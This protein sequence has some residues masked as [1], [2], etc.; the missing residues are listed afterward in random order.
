[1]GVL[2]P[3]HQRRS[4]RRAVTVPCQ[5][6]R[7]R[8]FKL[9]GETTMDL[10]LDGMMVHTWEPVLTGEDVL[11]SFCAPGL[12]MWFDAEAEVARVVHGRRPTDRGRALGLTFRRI[13]R[14]S[15]SYLKA[16]L[17]RLPPAPPARQP[18]INYAETVTRI[19]LGLDE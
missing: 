16:G 1:M 15:Q 10:S 9:L 18:R 4:L 5:V 19:F 8:D 7:E 6:V 14:L 17:E 3:L 2:V 11:V 12:R 13:D